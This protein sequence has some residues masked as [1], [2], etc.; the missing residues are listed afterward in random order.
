M[1]KKNLIK[2]FFLLAFFSLPFFSA[3]ALTVAPARL[4]INGNPGSQLKIDMILMNDKDENQVFYSS[5]ANFEAQGESGTPNFTEPKEGLGTWMEVPKTVSLIP[6]ES[7]TIPVVV[8]IPESAD[9]GGHF[10]AVFWSTVPPGISEPGQVAI[11]AKLGVLV[12]LKVNGEISEKGSIMNFETKDGVKNFSALP[13]SFVYR[14]NNA[15]DD[16]AKP[17][18]N[19]VIKN[20]LGMKSAVIDGNPSQGNVLPR[21]VRR[22]DVSWSKKNTPNDGTV[23]PET[24]WDNVEYQW[25]NF[26]FGRYTATLS[27]VYTS[28][29]IS[30]SAVTSFFV[31]PWQLLIIIIVGLILAFIIL[32]KIMHGYNR[33]L[34]SQVREE[35]EEEVEE[36]MEERLE[37][38]K[39]LEEQ[40]QHEEQK[41]K[42]EESVTK[43]EI[44]KK[45]KSKRKKN[46]HSPKA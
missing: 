15:G 37:V 5:Y 21:S 10:A 4:E 40:A 46:H 25:H 23:L 1:N 13:V 18:G 3:K 33:M 30:D 7:K 12:L 20:I 2:S 9:P 34:I 42:E 41:E 22:F 29:N 36:K 19:L 44:N 11:G 26:A 6:F 45:P 43:I 39:E 31:F 28:K 38:Q 16:R 8:T 27:L 32:R 17:T 14:F 35:I 24:F